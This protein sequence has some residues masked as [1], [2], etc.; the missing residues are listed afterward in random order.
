MIVDNLPTRWPTL[1]PTLLLLLLL[2]LAF[3]G[4]PLANAHP[5]VK[6]GSYVTLDKPTYNEFESIAIAF[7][8][9]PL[10]QQRQLRQLE[11]QPV[12]VLVRD[13]DSCDPDEVAVCT[14]HWNVTFGNNQQVRRRG[15]WPIKAN[16]TNPGMDCIK[17]NCYV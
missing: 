7:T 17:L 2:L 4:G 3:H 15:M 13:A 14:G 11:H 10:K 1:L 12:R 5:Q 16:I 8:T 6:E 9:P